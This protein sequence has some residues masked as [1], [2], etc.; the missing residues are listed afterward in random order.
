MVHPILLPP[1]VIDI[2]CPIS[3]SKHQA[4]RPNQSVPFCAGLRLLAINRQRL[5]DNP[6]LAPWLFIILGQIQILI[7][8]IGGTSPA[9]KKTMLDLVTNYGA[10]TDSPANSRVRTGGGYA[11]KEL[12]SNKSKALA[13]D[14]SSGG[15]R[16]AP[17]VG[18]SHRNNAVAE[19]NDVDGTG[20]ATVRRV[21]FDATR[22]R[23]AIRT[24]GAEAMLTS[25][26][27]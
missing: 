12:K 17:F 3:L 22:L 27:Y 10:V 8:I 1:L 2:V 18:S 15:K 19:R 9:L 21:S 20:M 11:L 5:H 14:A 25:D 16:F 6:T 26:V 23:L 4:D 7:S 24:R 13:S